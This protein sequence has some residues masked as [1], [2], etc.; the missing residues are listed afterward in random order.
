MNHWRSRCKDRHGSAPSA[1]SSLFTKLKL[2]FSYVQCLWGLVFFMKFILTIFPWNFKGLLLMQKSLKSFFTLV[3]DKVAGRSVRSGKLLAELASP[4]I[5]RS[6]SC[7]IR[8]HT[9]LSQNSDSRADTFKGLKLTRGLYCWENNSPNLFEHR[10]L[11]FTKL[12]RRIPKS[13]LVNEPRP[14]ASYRLLIDFFLL[15]V[16]WD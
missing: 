16:E 10:P 11:L 12:K 3:S 14:S 9:L 4:V 13:L 2:I 1:F 6:E 8:D 7:A 15:I 5:L